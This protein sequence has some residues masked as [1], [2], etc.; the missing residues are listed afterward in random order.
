MAAKESDVKNLHLT[1]RNLLRQ[2]AATMYGFA[3]AELPRKSARRVRAGT[4][5]SDSFPYEPRLL[6][7]VQT[8]RQ[9]LAARASPSVPLPQ[10]LYVDQTAFAGRL[11][12]VNGDGVRP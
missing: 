3:G 11:H 8:I 5:V 4:M 9:G 12:S 7:W 1:R 6:A 10:A 2:S